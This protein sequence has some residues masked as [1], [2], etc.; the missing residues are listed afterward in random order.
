L[1]RFIAGAAQAY[2]APTSSPVKKVGTPGRVAW[3]A[4]A[5]ALPF[6]PGFLRLRSFSS[7]EHSIRDSA[8][9]GV[10]RQGTRTGLALPR[11]SI[12]SRV[13]VTSDD[14]KSLSLMIEMWPV[15]APTKYEL[16]I[17]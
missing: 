4:G 13:T 2:S 3:A 9:P 16:I 14:P 12:L 11:P 6:P 15:Q 1:A 5:A 7:S 17:T 8:L 10:L